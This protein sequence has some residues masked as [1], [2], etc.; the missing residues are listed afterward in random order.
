MININKIVKITVTG[1]RP[2]FRGR[3]TAKYHNADFYSPKMSIEKM[4]LNKYATK[5]FYVDKQP[6]KAVVY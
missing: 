3:L 6:F 2:Q 1:Y 4:Y 5:G